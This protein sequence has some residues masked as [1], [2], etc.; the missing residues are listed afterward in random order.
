LQGRI[1][2]DC[3]NP[4]GAGLTHALG[5]RE[6]GAEVVQRHAIGARVVKAFSVYGWENFANNRYPQAPALRPAMPLAGDDAGAKARVAALCE[7]LGWEPVDCGPLAAALQ[8]E[9]LALLWIRMARQL[10][11]GPDFVWVR[12]RR[13]S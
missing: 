13:G 9:H 11:A 8:L 10:G 3:T 7:R 6:S 2:V 12:L 5:G 4:V 1:L